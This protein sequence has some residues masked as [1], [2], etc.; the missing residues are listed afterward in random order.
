MSSPKDHL[1]P[2][3]LNAEV[4][5]SNFISQQEK[6]GQLLLLSKNIDLNK[7]KSQFRSHHLFG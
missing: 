3:T 7:L 4:V 6:L 1:P 2:A 5:L